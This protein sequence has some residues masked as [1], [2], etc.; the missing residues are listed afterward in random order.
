MQDTSFNEGTI[1]G[2]WVPAF[3][4][5]DKYDYDSPLS[6]GSIPSSRTVKFECLSWAFSF[7]SV[8]FFLDPL[9]CSVCLYLWK[10]S[11][12][13]QKG[14]CLFLFLGLNFILWRMW[15]SKGLDKAKTL[16]APSIFQ[17]LWQ[18]E[19]TFPNVH[20]SPPTVW[21]YNQSLSTTLER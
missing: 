2:F 10:A 6:Q 16:S 14:Q 5:E 21:L 11:R 1:S 13:I 18:T 20:P 3:W 17:H 12:I 8:A 19:N 7:L 15:I 9:G 4:N